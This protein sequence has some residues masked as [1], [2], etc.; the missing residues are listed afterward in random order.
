MYSYL[1]QQTESGTH[2][3]QQQQRRQDRHRAQR[4]H[5]RHARRQRRAA[6]RFMPRSVQTG[7]LT[8]TCSNKPNQARNAAS[9]EQ[10]SK[11]DLW[12]HKIDFI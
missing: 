12:G 10:I 2:H 1:Q 5:Q 11:Y 3:K 9:Y 4:R 7:Y 8:L 6:L